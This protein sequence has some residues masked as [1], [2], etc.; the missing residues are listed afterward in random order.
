M[1][2]VCPKCGLKKPLEAFHRSNQSKDGRC[3]WCRDCSNVRS[4]QYRQEHPQAAIEYGRQYYAAHKELFAKK[5]QARYRN[6]KEEISTQH[7]QYYREHSDKIK[8]HVKAYVQSAAG[9]ESR[10]RVTKRHSEKYPE[11][12]K[13]RRAVNHSIKRGELKPAPF[14]SCHE[15]QIRRAAEYHHWHGYKPEHWLD[16]I[17]VCTSCHKRIDKQ[18]R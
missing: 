8:K 3:S 13:A 16:V 6:K 18:A 10:R 4:A 11:K 15:C 7:R 14:Y 12:I 2:K 5:G 1:T 9:K 17:P